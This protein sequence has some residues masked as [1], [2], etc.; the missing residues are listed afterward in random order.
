MASAEKAKRL[1][2]NRAAARGK[3]V[4]ADEQAAIAK[5][6]A[7]RPKDLDD[8]KT[9]FAI[10]NPETLAYTLDL[11]GGP[12][13][14]EI[15]TVFSVADIQK[16]RVFE[17][18]EAYRSLVVTEVSRFN[19]DARAGV[20]DYGFASSHPEYIDAAMALSHVRDFA[21]SLVSQISRYADLPDGAD[22]YVSPED[23]ARGMPG[24]QLAALSILILQR[25]R[26]AAEQAAN[27]K[28]VEAAK[29]A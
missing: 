4:S 23:L 16:R 29:R 18:I 22:A 3:A 28:N 10:L 13:P 11:P 7:S 14:I 21:R 26:Q 24:I 15:K 6:D 2:G 12:R 5:A 20:V 1:A 9:Q 19:R 8:P 25:A 27:S 17:N